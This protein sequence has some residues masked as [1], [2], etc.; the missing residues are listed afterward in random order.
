MDKMHAEGLDPSFTAIMP[1]EQ[2]AD[3][4]CLLYPDG[5]GGNLTISDSASGRLTP[6]PPVESTE[7]RSALP[8][9]APLSST[10][11]QLRISS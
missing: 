4:I 10:A 5:S 2:T 3:C 1:G 7:G 6:E 8:K 9:T 11:I